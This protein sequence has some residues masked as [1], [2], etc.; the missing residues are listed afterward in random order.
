[1]PEEKYYDKKEFIQKIDQLVDIKMR[2]MTESEIAIAK[3]D[4]R[5]M[6]CLHQ[7]RVDG[8]VEGDD[9]KQNWFL[10]NMITKLASVGYLS[11]IHI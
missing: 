7:I 9:E 3:S 5:L 2:K 8:H 6:E 11:L 10:I 4:Q 1:M